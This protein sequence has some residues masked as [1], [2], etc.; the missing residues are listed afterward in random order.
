MLSQ[1]KSRHGVGE[2]LLES[3]TWT[4]I[5]CLESIEGILGRTG[6][7]ERILG[8]KDLCN[9]PHLWKPF[10]RNLIPWSPYE[11]DYLYNLEQNTKPWE[12][13]R[14]GEDGRRLVLGGS[15]IGTA[16]GL[17]SYTPSRLWVRCNMN[18][19]SDI[20]HDPTIGADTLVRGHVMEPVTEL[21]VKKVTGLA[22]Q[23][24]GIVCHPTIP[25]HGIS[26]DGFVPGLALEFKSPLFKP[27]VGL[28]EYAPQLIS[29]MECLDVPANLLCSC[30]MDSK[31]AEITIQLVKRNP[32]YFHEY[33]IP[34]ADEALH[35][36][37]CH[38]FNFQSK[39][40]T[41][42][43]APKIEILDLFERK[44]RRDE[45]VA[46]MEAASVPMEWQRK[47]LAS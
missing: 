36:L 15:S 27:L 22:P 14:R 11:R 3:E 40:F 43:V 45:L 47:V 24:C 31:G 25:W 16:A 23:H 1:L 37:E 44:F 30:H 41:K 7:I 32:I 8:D 42:L 12:D 4:I 28:G 21:F 5:R 33:L 6:P 19:Y 26:P 17:S 35:A 29:Q 39:L 20:W 9:P 38:D 46:A 2:L 34:L 10:C 18:Y 13:A